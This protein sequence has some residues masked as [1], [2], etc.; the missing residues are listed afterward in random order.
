MLLI[1]SLVYATDFFPY[2]FYVN[3]Y[4]LSLKIL[5]SHFTVSGTLRTNLD[6]FNLHDDATLWD[7]LKRS[8]LVADTSKRNSVGQEEDSPS[9]VHTP[10]NRF[11]LDT[12]IEDEGGNLSIGQVCES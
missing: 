12:V 10:V 5:C 11:T 9:G 2:S 8:Y 6:P 7:A 3:I 1:S 4:A